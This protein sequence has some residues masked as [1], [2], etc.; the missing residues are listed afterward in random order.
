MTMNKKLYIKTFMNMGI[1]F[2]LVPSSMIDKD[3]LEEAM[4]NGENCDRLFSQYLDGVEMTAIYLMQ[5]LEDGCMANC[6]FCTQSRESIHKR[7]KSYLVDKEMI[8]IPLESLKNFL[9]KN[10]KAKEIRRIC[11]QTVYNTQT[12]PNLIETVSAL[13]EVTD[14]PITAC[15]IPVSKEIMEQLKSVGVNHITINYEVA[16]PELFDKFRGI[17]RKS[18]YRWEKI[19][20]AIDDAVEVFGKLNVGSLLLVGLGETQQDI[21]NM[22]QALNEKGVRVSLFA[23]TPIP[24]TDMANAQRVSHGYYHQVQLGSYLIK[25]NRVQAGQMKFDSGGMI[26]DYGIQ[27]EELNHII[28]SGLPFKNAGCPGCNRVFY[29]TNPKER[30]YSYPRNLLPSETAQIK[31]EILEIKHVNTLPNK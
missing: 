9:V 15:S 14:I 10:P 28:D 31:Q 11:M 23:F 4:G 19:T 5:H 22:I 8:R 24:D 6:A 18:P 1:Y 29:E 2:G 3:V 25:N 30:P 27:A 12:V 26:T 21:L 7:R 16:T 17:E 20:Q 13:R